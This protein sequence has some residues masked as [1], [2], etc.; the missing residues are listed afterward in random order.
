MY[1]AHALLIV[2]YHPT[3][4]P[5]TFPFISFYSIF[6]S[7]IIDCLQEAL[8]NPK[9]YVLKP[10]LEGGAGNYYGQEVAEMIKKLTSDEMAAH[11]LMERIY[12]KAVKV[13]TLHLT[14]SEL[15]LSVY[16]N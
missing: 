10:Q 9:L 1:Y 12:P 6:L 8:S 13:R 4:L 14:F 11:I 5:S 15:V 3:C 16:F 2:S 7:Y